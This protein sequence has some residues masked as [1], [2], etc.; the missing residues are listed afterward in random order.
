MSDKPKFTIRRVTPEEKPPSEPSPPPQKQQ[1]TPP[2]SSTTPTS[3]GGVFPSANS[4]LAF[5]GSFF[6]TTLS[7]TAVVRRTP[8]RTWWV[9]VAIPSNRIAPLIWAAGG[10]PFACQNQQWIALSL[11]G[12]IPPDA[13]NSEK[14]DVSSWAIVDLAQLFAEASLPPSRY[15][16]ATVLDI[17]TP[18]SLGRWILRRA[19]A[20]GLEVTITPALQYPL[21]N[22]QHKGSGVLLLQMR[23]PE[24]QRQRRSPK[25]RPI[26][27]ALVHRLTSL[28]Y[29]TVAASSS[30]TDRP[31]ILVDVRQRLSLAPSLIEPMIP[32]SEIWVLGTPDVGNWRVITTGDQVDGSLL[33]DAPELPQAI[34]PI[35]NKPQL[36]APIPVQLVPR[37]GTGR[38]V[39]AV[40][41]DDTELPWLR[42]LLMGRPIGEMAFLLPGAGYHLLTAPGGL[43]AQI[44]LGIPLVCTGSGAF[45]LEL[46]MDFYPPLPDAACQERF[47][48]NSQTAVVVA[49]NQTYRFN[50]AQM[51]PAW[52][53]W[54]GE[55][56]KVQE[57]LSPQ[58]KKLLN[59]IPQQLQQQESKKGILNIFK[60][61]QTKRVEG[62][63]LLEQAQQAELKGDLVHAATLL[64]QA[65]YPAQAGRLYERMAIGGK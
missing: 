50:T 65:G 59:S 28:P 35:L 11:S 30:D 39:D 46:G 37:P 64:E 3:T 43:P 17:I 6:G 53:L 5:L 26:S 16:G 2:P 20:L 23:L 55:A 19:T 27:P 41:I 4:V 42:K 56:P 7:E 34:S 15:R 14:L 31:R 8:Q 13:S 49:R 38:Q 47:Q 9:E 63:G 12:D 61:K 60:P 25:N 22:Q 21:N 32:E 18:G 45:Y 1:Q 44:P 40:L 51:I 29:T 10:R 54:V 52:A 57:D 36:P 48:L 62:V 33:L 24:G 58:G